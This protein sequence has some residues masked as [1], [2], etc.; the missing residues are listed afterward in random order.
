MAVVESGH[1]IDDAVE[2]G[3]PETGLKLSRECRRQRQREGEKCDGENKECVLHG[4]L[5]SQEAKKRAELRQR[6][7]AFSQKE[8]GRIRTPQRNLNA[9]WASFA[10]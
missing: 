5:L 10:G 9:R 4:G 1:G 8:P 3:L 2:T 6:S 7:G